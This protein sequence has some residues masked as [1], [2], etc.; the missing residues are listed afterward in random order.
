MTADWD[1]IVRLGLDKL[2]YGD[3]VLLENCDNTYGRGY[4]TGAGDNRRGCTF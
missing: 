4:L 1:E 3:I 2:R